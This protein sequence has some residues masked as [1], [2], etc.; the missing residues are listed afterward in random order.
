MPEIDSPSASVVVN[1]RIEAD[2]AL[3]RGQ[4]QLVR[5]ASAA[6][7][8][9]AKTF[10]E[11]DGGLRVCVMDCSPGLLAGDC[12]EFAW[13]LEEEARVYITNQ[14]FT[15]IHPSRGRF[16]VQNQHVKVARGARLEL[17]PLP[18]M[19][20]RDADFRSATTV[21]IESG[22]AFILSD[23]LCAGRI[24]RDEF[25]FASVRNKLHVRL[26]N[27]LIHCSQTRFEPL[28]NSLRV[29]GAW[30]M[31]THVATFGA[32]FEGAEC[33]LVD[34]MRAVLRDF[35]GLKS[36][37][38]LAHRHGVLVSMLGARA[39]EMQAACEVL[40]MCVRRSLARSDEARG[41]ERV[42]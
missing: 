26:N 36:G 14:S 2:F 27:E 42:E 29:R 24:G 30:D 23:I 18:V 13:R 10:A 40:R 7:L 41:F 31:S 22:G 9:I 5:S 6:P 35:P 20:F 33:D 21:E 19:P 11:E 16:C 17:F 15:K 8:K 4:T 3:A 39:W 1:G 38:S 37:V 34:Q 28:R 32:W 12:Y 25:E